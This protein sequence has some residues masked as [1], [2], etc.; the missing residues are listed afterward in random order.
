MSDKQNRPKTAPY[1]VHCGAK[2]ESGQ[3]YC[4]ECGKLAFTL[5]SGTKDPNI[6]SAPA[7][8]RR[9]KSGEFIRQ[10]PGCGSII[11]SKILEQCPICNTILGKIPE[12]VKQEEQ[13]EKAGLVFTDKKLQPAQKFIVKKE[14][15]NFKEGI[16]IFF[17]ALWHYILAYFLIISIFW[18]QSDFAANIEIESSIHMF[19]IGQI[20]TI[21]FGIY[22]LWYIFSRGHK[23]EKLG[24]HKE[25]NMLSK[26]L[27]IGMIGALI[28]VALNYILNVFNTAV[29]E[30]GLDIFDMQAYLDDERTILQ[31]APILLIVL[32][33]FEL[34]IGAISTEILFRGVLHN[35]LKEKFDGEDPLSRF[36]VILIV[37]LI[38]SGVYLLFSLLIGVVFFLMNFLVFILLGLLYEYNENLYNSIFAHAI[39]QILLVVVIMLM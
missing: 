5:Q 14:S 24:L 18:F 26:A 30:I 15:W 31:E 35:T 13:E 20:P 17:M 12:H 33:G 34:V 37:A 3:T 8:P 25:D 9:K 7:L 29:F 16:N 27:I 6:K 21:I 11:S 10:C 28:L 19:L 39:Y 32:L 23:P 1:C 22:P 36:Y 2:V 4:P 38:Y